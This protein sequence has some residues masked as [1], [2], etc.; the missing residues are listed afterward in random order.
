MQREREWRALPFVEAAPLAAPLL[1]SFEQQ[2]ALD[3]EAPTRHADGE[4]LLER[5][6]RAARDDVA[7][8]LGGMPGLP[9]ESECRDAVAHAVTRV[10]V[11]LNE[12]PVIASGASRVHRR[13]QA[14]RVIAD[15]RLAEAEPACDLGAA[16]AL[17]R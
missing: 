10:V 4:Q 13:A 14:A 8:Q 16:H 2:P 17:A 1:E 15:G 3:V 12:R 9:G 6:G 5:H 11:G 7:T